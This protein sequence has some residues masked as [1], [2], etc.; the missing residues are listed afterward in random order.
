MNFTVT[1]VPA[2][3]I[4]LANLWLVAIDREG[5]LIAA[6]QIDQQ[7]KSDPENFGESRSAQRRIIIVPPLAVTYHVLPA[8]RF[9]QILNVRDFAPQG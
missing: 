2:A 1:W 4:E 9:V 8:D 7:L 3:E 6:D 5:L